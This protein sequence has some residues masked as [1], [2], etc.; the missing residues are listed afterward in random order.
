MVV[1][2]LIGRIQYEGDELLGVYASVEDAE[3]ARDEY[4]GIEGSQYFSEYFIRPQTLGA[5]AVW[6][7]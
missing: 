5:P 3:R 6:D 2:A 1:Y 7:F 4:D